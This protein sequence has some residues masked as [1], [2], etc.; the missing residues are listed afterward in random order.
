MNDLLRL[1]IPEA[2]AEVTEAFNCYEVALTTNYVET[3]GELFK[4]APYIFRF[5][6][7]ENLYGL[8]EIKAFRKARP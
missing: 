2:L 3:L 1:D 5:G 7:T 4:N 6:M 8:R